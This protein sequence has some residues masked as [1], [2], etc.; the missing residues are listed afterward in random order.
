MNRVEE[1]RFKDL[2]SKVEQL[3]Q[4]IQSLA[5][6]GGQNEELDLKLKLE[7]VRLK[8]DNLKEANEIYIY[9]KEGKLPKK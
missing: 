7:A 6:A 3:K 1:Q 9:L 4:A 2:E 5:Y 8:P